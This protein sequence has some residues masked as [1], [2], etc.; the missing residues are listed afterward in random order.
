MSNQ[1]W[2]LPEPPD[3][4][5]TGGRR[6]RGA[7]LVEWGAA[8]LVVAVVLGVLVA[9]VPGSVTTGVQSAICRVFGTQC[10]AGQ[11]A[12]AGEQ[13]G[14]PGPQSG[15][16]APP[17]TAPATPPAAQAPSKAQT[18]TESVLGETE[19]GREA[20]EWAKKNGVTFR[21]ETGGGSYYEDGQHRIT[22]NAGRTPERR[23]ASVVHEVNHARGRNS[24]DVKAM[25]RD[26]FI[27]ASLNEEIDGTVLAIRANQ[28]LRD[29]RGKANPP[30]NAVLQTEYETAYN[31]A[32]EQENA[33]RAKNGE[34]AMTAA[35]ARRTGETAGRLRVRQAF[36]NGEVVA[37]TTGKKYRDLY[38]E[39]WDNR[40]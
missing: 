26:E 5:G 15:Q 36:E 21:Y 28:Q 9:A 4:S 1:P 19:I 27:N 32:V 34:A 20:L 16:S 40:H 22:I 33:R 13:A 8:L 31:K 23:A 14:V 25:E 30:E 6:E 37:S 35:E 38:G 12:Q 24:P 10:A 29:A 7:S 11:S 18:E 17:A 3:P 2:H 39:D